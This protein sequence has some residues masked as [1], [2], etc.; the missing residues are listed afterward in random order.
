MNRK[1]T[2][3][4]TWGDKQVAVRISDATIARLDAFCASWQMPDG[5]PPSRSEAVRIFVED[6]LARVEHAARVQFAQQ[7][8]NT[9]RQRQALLAALILAARK[10]K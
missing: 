1:K 3:D 4:A 6:G 5:N 2:W 9:A 7:Q 8:D 10:P